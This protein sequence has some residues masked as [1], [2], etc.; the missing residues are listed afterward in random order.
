MALIIDK[1]DAH[2]TLK[3]LDFRFSLNGNSGQILYIT[4][5]RD[6][7]G[8]IVSFDTSLW[9]RVSSEH[10]VLDPISGFSVS[11][12]GEHLAM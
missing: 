7:E 8:S 5:M 6:R 10:V 3:D 11:P 12:D 2:P 4:A 1:A 9:T